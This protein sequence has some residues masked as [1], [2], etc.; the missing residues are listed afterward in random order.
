MTQK[1]L[2]LKTGIRAATINALYHEQSA[3]ISLENL[4]KLCEAL[5]CTVEDILEYIPNS[6]YIKYHKDK[7]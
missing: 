2:A 4:D 7:K 5:D 6:E 3:E 1:E